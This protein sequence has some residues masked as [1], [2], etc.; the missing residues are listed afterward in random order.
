MSRRPYTQ[1]QLEYLLA[2][3]RLTREQDGIP[4]CVRD[5]MR[6]VGC[7]SSSSAYYQLQ[8]LAR[9]GWIRYIRWR[10]YF[11]LNARGVEALEAV[12]PDAQGS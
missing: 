4:P 10:G 5:V 6:A 12:A 3:E 1:R 8:A 9:K 2:F 7:T 11:P